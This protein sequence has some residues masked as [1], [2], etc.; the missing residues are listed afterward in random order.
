MKTP[1]KAVKP[2]ARGSVGRSALRTSA[3]MASPLLRDQSLRAERCL[4][5]RQVTW[6]E[7]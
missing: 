3:R 5:W 2:F 1:D 6:S 4:P 7:R